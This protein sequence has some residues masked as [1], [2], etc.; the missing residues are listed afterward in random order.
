M[1]GPDFSSFL[2]FDIS[3]FHQES[4]T[5]NYPDGT[6]ATFAFETFDNP[7]PG[8]HWYG[9]SL[10][11][12]TFLKNLEKLAK[13][14]VKALIEAI[15]TANNIVKEVADALIRKLD[16]ILQTVQNVVAIVEGFLVALE[17]TGV[18]YFDIPT[19]SGGVDYVIQSIQ[20]S[21]AT[22]TG[23][24][25]TVASILDT[26]P[27]SALFFAG[28]GYGVDLKAWEALFKNA[29]DETNFAF[30]QEFGAQFSVIPSFDGAVFT[31]GTPVNL[32]VVSQESTEQNQLYYT[33][34]ITDRTGAVV[35]SQT[36]YLTA[37][38]ARVNKDTSIITFTP[39]GNKVG[40][41]KYH[42]SIKVFNLGAKS[43]TYDKDFYVT[44]SISNV[45]TGIDSDGKLP[46]VTTGE[47]GGTL[48]LVN[49]SIPNGSPVEEIVVA[50][51]KT[52]TVGTTVSPSSTNLQLQYVSA[53]DDATTFTVPV[54]N[55]KKYRIGNVNAPP[56]PASFRFLSFPAKVCFNFA[57]S[58]KYRLKGASTWTVIT[59]PA[60]IKVDNNASYEYF[61]F[62]DGTWQGPLTFGIVT[63]DTE[64]TQVC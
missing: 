31:Y 63:Q 15:K 19:N 33:Y 20:N 29:F 12:F 16:I 41:L 59:L 44:D 62:T 49:A 36:N 37:N 40:T 10:E 13:D 5:I 64:G 58:L 56:I 57:G 25:Q 1:V 14:L 47:C 30:N 48:T 26:M 2:N 27:F 39:P 11:N 46:T 60:C 24:A 17:S 54:E 50:P 8:L 45:T 18:Y 35:S 22:P 43:A 38:D 51:N 55:N 4:Y 61:L 6:S 21:L 9:L 32:Q 42:I 3:G 23:D 53:C 34:T 52:A 28:A 7:V